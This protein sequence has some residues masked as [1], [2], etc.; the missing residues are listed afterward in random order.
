MY[1]VHN[2]LFK[3]HSW[4]GC[5]REEGNPLHLLGIEPHILQCIALSL[6][7]LRCSSTHVHA[8]K[9]CVTRFTRMQDI[10]T[11]Q[12]IKH[13]L[14]Q[15]INYTVNSNFIHLIHKACPSQCHCLHLH[16]QCLHLPHTYSQPSHPQH[17]HSTTY[18]HQSHP[19]HWMYGTF[20]NL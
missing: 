13:L 1:P 10:Q 12:K 6:N 20:D 4:S 5:F 3:S 14:I 2:S 9:K 7:D 17:C 11:P 15:N 19:L 18:H 16:S 8:Q